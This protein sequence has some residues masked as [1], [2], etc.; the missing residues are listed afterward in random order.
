MPGSVASG[1]LCVT[2]RGTEQFVEMCRSEI[3]AM[4]P[5]KGPSTY[6]KHKHMQEKEDSIK[7]EYNVLFYN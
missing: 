7:N 6:A 5:R 4:L 3:C 2:E 1:T